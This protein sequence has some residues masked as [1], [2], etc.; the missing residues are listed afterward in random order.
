VDQRRSSN[1]D[2]SER[3]EPLHSHAQV[4]VVGICKRFGATQALDAV[5]VEIEAGTIHA[6][7]GENGAGK[8]TLGKI[9]GG[10]YVADVGAAVGGGA[11]SAV[12]GAGA[13]VGVVLASGVLET[14]ESPAPQ[15]ASRATPAAAAVAARCRRPGDSGRH[16]TVA[17]GTAISGDDPTGGAAGRNDAGH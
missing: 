3:D 16:F 13:A 11:G 9:I 8:S 4:S 6:L 10:V 7:V 1:C 17:H 2:S 5:S 14:V 15:P 12:A